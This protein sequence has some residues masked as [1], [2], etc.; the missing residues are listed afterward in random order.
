MVESFFSNLYKSKTTS[1]PPLNPQKIIIDVDCGG[2]DAH[3][4][5]LAIHLAKKFNV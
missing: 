5:I 2:D 1:Y 3:S 4:L